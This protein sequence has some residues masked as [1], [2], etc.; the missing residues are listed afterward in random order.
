MQKSLFSVNHIMIKQELPR[1]NVKKDVNEDGASQRETNPNPFLSIFSVT[2]ARVIWDTVYLLHE[3]KKVG[4][5]DLDKY[6]TDL[7]CTTSARHGT[8]W[9]ETNKLQETKFAGGTVFL[10]RPKST[11]RGKTSETIWFCINLTLI[12][13]LK[14]LQLNYCTGIKPLED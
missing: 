14:P 6:H 11:A 8:F 12:K 5:W 4:L 3:G 9:D 2:L 13:A 7:D 10:I 1:K